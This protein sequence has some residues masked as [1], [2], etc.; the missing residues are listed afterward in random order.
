MLQ[1]SQYISR[2]ELDKALALGDEALALFKR[3]GV[4]FNI[5]ITLLNLGETYRMLGEW[6]KSEQYLREALDTAKGQDEFQLLGWGPINRGLLHLDKEEYVRAKESF[7]EGLKV[8]EKVGK[9][10]QMY[11]SRFVCWTLIE[12][13]ELEKAQDLLEKLQSLAFEAGEKWSIVWSIVLGAMLLRAQKKFDES[14]ELFEKALKE[15]GSINANIWDAYYFAR[16]VLCE[17]A[18]A[19][20]ERN[21][22]G[23]KEKARG[24]LNRALEMFQKMGAKKDV[25]KV[26]ARLLY[27][28]TGKVASVSKPAELVCSGYAD[29]DKLLCGGIP[30]SCAVVLTSPSCIE[31]DLLV[32]SF[33]ETGAK[34]GE[35]AF[36]V[37]INPGPTKILA[38]EFPSN[39]YL[40]VCNP[41]ADA[42]V[43]DAPNVVKL[44]GV[45]SLTDISIAL[46]SAIR[47]L[48]SSTN[49]Q[50][51]ICLGVVSDV[52]L[53][54]HAVQTRRWLA[55]LMPELQSEGFTTLALIDPQVH[56][57]EEL[58]AISGLFDGEIDIREKETDKGIQ[59]YLKIKRMSDHEYLEEELPLKKE[60]L[61][62]LSVKGLLSGKV[63]QVK[64]Q[65]LTT[66]HPVLDKHRIAVLPFVNM[67]PD[68]DDEY[69]ADGMTE[70]IISTVS[71]ISG[72]RVISRTSVM[73]YKKTEKA[74]KEIGRELEVGSILEGS[75]RKAGNRI[76]V[77]TQLIDVV[78]DSHLWAQNYDRNLDDIFEVQSD[79]AKQ[80]AD[81]LRIRILFPQKER[82][83]K[84]PTESVEAHTLYLKGVYQL[85]KW[86]TS[87]WDRAIEYFKLAC[88]QDPAF[89]LAYA[90]VA[91]CYVLTADVGMPS[92]EAIPKAKEYVSRALSLDDSLAEAHYAQALVANQSDWDWA[93]AEKSFKMA[94]SL[95]PSL[96]DAHNYYAWF[97]GMI[98]RSKEAASEAAKACELDPMSPATLALSGWNNIEAADYG[99]AR[100]QA[101]RA[102]EIAPDLAGGHF[103]LALLNA[104]EGKFEEAVREADEAAALAGDVFEHEWQA[105]VYAMAGLKEKA[106][107]I[108]DDVLSRKYPGYPCPSQIGTIYYLLGEKDRGWEWMQKAYKARDTGLVMLNRNPARK[109]A[110]E[111]LRYLDLLKKLGLN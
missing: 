11:Y 6:E 101:M 87:G 76:R 32:K 46:T 18:R 98:G 83:E 85:N 37:T 89:A 63:S 22:D 93:K 58:H 82:I 94:L 66:E 8:W 56:L 13:G 39:F 27:I 67:S 21:A 26:E 109:S 70:E 107:E 10:G 92:S 57:S 43:K 97:L 16:L 19:C 71:G 7:E 31:R 25:E 3:I 17:Y 55:G 50:R 35:V 72:L 44:K 110:R 53:Q 33:L 61:K 2:G 47:K 90:R 75:F 4:R 74:M 36:Y 100:V 1:A 62:I 12:L 73:R 51:R 78:T 40:F 103:D 102:V 106:R 20:M 79:I 49:G 105:Q 88:E 59:K 86:T 41:Q 24:L 77:T 60:D 108:L 54:H 30:S 64:P 52:L 29:L 14:V 99:R 38:E 5:S 104:A 34:K 48:D 80:V 45:E 23:D 84:K 42:I 95:N 69:F 111:D 9:M 68:P 81:A 28:E 65:E 91:E 96:A 15:W